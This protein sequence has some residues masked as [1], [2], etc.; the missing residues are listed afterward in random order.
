[1]KIGMSTP[2]EHDSK[3]S[4]GSQADE[5]VSEPTS[6]GAKLG[7]RQDYGAD[8]PVGR[9]ATTKDIRLVEAEGQRRARDVGGSVRV[10]SGT[11]VTHG[12]SIKT[13]LR[14]GGRSAV[15]KVR[16]HLAIAL[17]LFLSNGTDDGIA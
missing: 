6:G 15:A 3:T 5:K 1:M 9:A 16:S 14:S 7:E 13:G 2:K 10:I 4:K 17:V 8:G 11:S 12:D